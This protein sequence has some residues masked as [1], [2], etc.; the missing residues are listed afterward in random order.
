[1][2]NMTVNSY[3][4]QST[5]FLKDQKLAYATRTKKYMSYLDFRKIIYA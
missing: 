3:F 5:K 4:L 1:M 2:N